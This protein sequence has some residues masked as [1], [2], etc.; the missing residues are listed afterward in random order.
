MMPGPHQAMAASEREPS[1]YAGFPPLTVLGAS[2][3]S[4]CISVNDR[5]VRLIKQ[6]TSAR[7]T[8]GI[9]TATRL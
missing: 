7:T 3:S 4:G 6:S 2:S 8:T 5:S 9:E 1:N